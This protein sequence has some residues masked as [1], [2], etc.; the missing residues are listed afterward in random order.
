V[1]SN[2][3]LVAERADQLQYVKGIDPY[4]QLFLGSKQV[5]RSNNQFDLVLFDNY[6][7]GSWY[8]DEKN[9][10]ITLTPNGSTTLLLKLDSLTPTK[11]QVRIDSNSFKKLSN[12]RNPSY[13]TAG[14]FGN[15]MII[16]A[17]EIDPR[18][19]L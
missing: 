8:L 14:W 2:A 10:E 16:F 6:Y 7:H 17:F 1:Y 18:T 12:F 4:K 19:F 5:F 11:L 9:K 13:A 15:R 3:P